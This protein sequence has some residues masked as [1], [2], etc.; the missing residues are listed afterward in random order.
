MRNRLDHVASVFTALHGT[1][2][3]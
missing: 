2:A 1:D 3:V